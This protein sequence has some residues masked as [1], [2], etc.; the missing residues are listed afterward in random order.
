V[1]TFFKERLFARFGS[2][3]QRVTIGPAAILLAGLSWP[4]ILQASSEISCLRC[5]EHESQVKQLTVSVHA[6]AGVT[7][8]D[9]HGGDSGAPDE[10]AHLASD[11]RR[12]DSKREIA[13]NCARCHADVR[14]MNPYGLPTDQLERYKTSRHGERLFQHGD[15][16]VASCT[17]CHG[18]HAILKVDSPDSPTYPANIPATC[19]RCHEDARLMA[20][21]GLPSDVVSRYLSS[22]HARLLVEKGDLSAP[23]CMTCHGNHG[24]TPPTTTEVSQVCGKCHVRQRELFEKSPHREAAALGVFNE[25]VECHG[26]HDIS[27]A[28]LKLFGTTCVRCHSGE[29]LPMALVGRISGLIDS[30]SGEYERASLLVQSAAAGGMATD[31][32]QILLQEGRT[33]LTR[34]EALQHTLSM[35]EIEPAAAAAAASI[36]QAAEQI[37]NKEAANHRKRLA[38]VPIWGFLSLMAALFWIKR[39]RLET[40]ESQ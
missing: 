17:D 7:C 3:R 29:A 12:P 16:N 31:D 24:A 26:N 35:E 11:F 21:C 32:E 2:V 33:A 38:L 34:M 14:R 36:G 1:Q 6:Q 22:T 15:E 20:A 30:L 18:V 4:E 10:T 8:I 28:S 27:K 40:E 5:H 37:Q 13:E 19:G 39:E 23:T 25:C 9:C